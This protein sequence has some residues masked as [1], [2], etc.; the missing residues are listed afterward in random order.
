V[1]LI[2]IH[3]SEGPYG[4]YRRAIITVRVLSK[5]YYHCPGII[6]GLLSLFGYYR[7]AII[8]VRVLSK[9]YYRR[10]IIEGLLSKGYY[11][12]AIIEGLLSNMIKRLHEV[13]QVVWQ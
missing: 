1:W 5:A 9:G 2:A 4:Y 12:R 8:I 3:C 11:R 7:R 6:E 13:V 10:V